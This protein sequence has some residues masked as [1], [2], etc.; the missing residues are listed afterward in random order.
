MT[1]PNITTIRDGLTPCTYHGFDW[2]D[3]CEECEGRKAEFDALDAVE[4]E[5]AD[6]R[7]SVDL[8]EAMTKE[9]ERSLFGADMGRSRDEIV[10]AAADLRAENE[11]LR[12]ALE[13][14]DAI[15]RE[16]DEYRAENERL[17]KRYLDA[18]RGRD[19]LPIAHDVL[20]QLEQAERERDEAR[21]ENERLTNRLNADSQDFEIC[22]L[23]ETVRVLRERAE[24]AERA[25]PQL[26][27]KRRWSDLC[28]YCKG[29]PQD[30]CT[31]KEGTAATPGE[32][33]PD[34][35]M[36]L[37]PGEQYEGVGCVFAEP[38]ETTT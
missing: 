17:N 22:C 36:D 20:A 1:D 30:G 32:E 18:V 27:D 23:R 35:G 24:D 15:E 16:L 28:G 5:L 29:Y 10:Q 2:Y 4:R 33:C 26:G 12:E 9:V 11:R 19:D 31:C 34:C 25:S 6:L 14:C 21:A 8:Y 13:T 3:E 7:E 38:R 37:E